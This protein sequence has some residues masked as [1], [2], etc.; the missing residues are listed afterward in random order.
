[1]P[2]LPP[3][4]PARL[5]L[6][7]ERAT[8]TRTLT[9]ASL[10]AA[11]KAVY[12]ATQILM[13]AARNCVNWDEV[14]SEQPFFEFGAADLAYAAARRG[15][16]AAR[17]TDD[18]AETAEYR[19][20]CELAD[21]PGAPGTGSALFGYRGPY[22]GPVPSG[23]LAGPGPVSRPAARTGGGFPVSGPS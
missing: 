2:P 9:L 3:A 7:V 5:T 21:W 22:R 15:Y 8:A 19:A 11:G 23:R 6:A 18:R 17:R 13:Q 12:A 20:R 10:R 4:P 16:A 1:M 14:D